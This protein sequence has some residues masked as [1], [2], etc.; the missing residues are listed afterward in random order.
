MLFSMSDRIVE[1]DPHHG[2][3]RTVCRKRE[4]GRPVRVHGLKTAERRIG[5]RRKIGRRVDWA[6]AEDAIDQRASEHDNR[7]ARKALGLAAGEKQ[8][9]LSWQSSLVLVAGFTA[10]TMIGQ[11][12]S[13]EIRLE[14]AGVTNCE[15]VIPAILIGRFAMSR[16]G[17]IN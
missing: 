10:G 16:P 14:R 13:V 11:P 8:K 5:A 6:V 4:R 1:D 2:D 7:H 9:R 3:R 15:C 17:L 12:E